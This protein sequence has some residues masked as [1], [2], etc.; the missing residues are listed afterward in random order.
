MLSVG[1]NIQTVEL[2]EKKKERKSKTKKKND[3]LYLNTKFVSVA[4]VSFFLF[5]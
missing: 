3:S 4:F 1:L 2:N 5:F